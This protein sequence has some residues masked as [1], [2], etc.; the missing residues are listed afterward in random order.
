MATVDGQGMVTAVAPGTA[1]ITATAD[2]VSATCTVTVTRPYTPP[3]NPNYRIDITD[4]ANGIV[5]ADPTSA[6][7]GTTVTL[8]PVP[9]EG[10]ALG[11]LAVTDRFGA[12]VA[13]TEQADGTY[14]FT[15]PNGQVTVSAT[16]VEA[17]EPAAEP[18]NRRGRERLVL[19]GR[20]LCLRERPDE[21][22]G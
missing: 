5:I 21:R 6:K 7:A 14:T 9:D 10:Y 1:T 11:S 19:R 20:G 22:R 13:L 16:F 18:F 3:A 15:M 8:T 2:G 17:E 12:P 4:T